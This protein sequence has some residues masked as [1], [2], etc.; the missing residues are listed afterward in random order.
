MTPEQRKK[1]IDFDPKVN[2][3]HILSILALMVS[4]FL[5]WENMKADIRQVDFSRQLGD[6]ALQGQIDKTTVVLDRLVKDVDDMK[7]HE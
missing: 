3:G 4:G 6:Q 2:M 7:D 1:F 5:A